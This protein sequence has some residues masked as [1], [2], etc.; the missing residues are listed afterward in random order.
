MLVVLDNFEHVLQAAS[1]VGE[2]LAECPAS[3]SW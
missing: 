1:A 3:Y 2:L